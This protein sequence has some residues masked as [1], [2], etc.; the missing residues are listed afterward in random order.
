LLVLLSVMLISSALAFKDNHYGLIADSKALK[1]DTISGFFLYEFDVPQKCYARFDQIE[2][3]HN[4]IAYSDGMSND[5]IIKLYRK[6]IFILEYENFLGNA[7]SRKHISQNRRNVDGF[8]TYMVRHS[9]EEYDYSL[10]HDKSG[11]LSYKK[12]Y[13]KLVVYN[14]HRRW[15]LTPKTD[16]YECCYSNEKRSI[17]TYFVTDILEY[18]VY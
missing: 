15:Q 2:R 4:L 1:P 3:L 18:K 17:P 12:I 11:I 5:D 6:G 14:L 13:A 16:D 8:L 10:I 7:T 9:G